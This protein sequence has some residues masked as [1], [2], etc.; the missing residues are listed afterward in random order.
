MASN[1]DHEERERLSWK[2]IDKLKDRSRH[3]TKDKG[4]RK[5]SFP[6][7]WAKRQYLKEAEK[8][9]SG[10]KGSEEHKA[11]HSAIHKCYG[12]NKFQSAVKKYLNQYGLPEDWGTL[13]L[14]LD[15]N[16][17]QTV[18]EAL[19]ALKNMYPTKSPLEKQGL[20]GKLRTLVL[21]TGDDELSEL[22][23]GVLNQL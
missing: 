18:K 1:H 22:A 5:S 12:S 17:T 7:K 15:Y 2:E 19:V 20:K 14:L 4:Y 13:L 8:L 16:D 11:A 3:V 6:S 21:T 9:F 10:K 23:E